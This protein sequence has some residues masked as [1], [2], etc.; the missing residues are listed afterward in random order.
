M[1]FFLQSSSSHIYCGGKNPRER[2][3]SKE[4]GSRDM[5]LVKWLRKNNKKVMAVVVIVI[6]FGFVGGAYIRQLSQRRSELSKTVA[7]FADNKKITNYDRA[8]ARRE[9]ETLRM[10]RTDVLLRNIVA[11]LSRIQDLRAFVL[12]ELLFSERTTSPQSV[13]YI[14]RL[15][16]FSDYGISDEQIDDIYQRSVGSEIYWLLLKKEAELAGIK[17]ANKYAGAQLARAIS[18]F[19]RRLPDFQ[20]LTYERLISATMDRQRIAEKEILATFAKLVAVLEYCVM[21]CA[22]E[23]VTNSQV[24]HDSIYEEETIDVEFVRFDSAVFAKIQNEPNDGKIYEHFQKYKTF[25]AGDVSKENPYGFGYK[26]PDRVQLEYI[27][28]MLDDITRIVAE[29]TDDEVEEYYD[30]H[31]EEFYELVPSDP[32]DPNSDPVRQ[33]KGYTEVASAISE[34]LLQRKVYSK[35]N[36]ILQEA[37]TRTEAGLEGTE[38][39]NLSTEQ[40]REMVGDYNAVAKQLSEEHK[41][42]VYAGQTGLLTA[43]DIQKDGYLGRLYVEGYGHSPPDFI[44]RVGLFRIVFSIDELGTSHLGPFDTARPRM[45]ENIGPLK[46]PLGEVIVLVRVID[47]VKPSVAES[48]NQVYDKS[49][50]KLGQDPNQADEA[51]YSVKEKVVEDLKKLAAMDTAKSKTEEFI[52]QVVMDG[53]DGAISKSNQL[54]GQDDQN[55]IDPNV[56]MLREPTGL[57]RISRQQMHKLE[58]Q[59]EGN[60]LGQLLVNE[61]K[62]QAEF[63]NRLYSLIPEDT[64]S[65]E[66][67]PF[68][69]KFEPHLSYYCL[70]NLSVKRLYQDQYETVKPF[71]IFRKDLA[72]SQYLAVIHFNPGNILDRMNFRLAE[73]LEP[74]DA[75]EPTE[76][77]DTS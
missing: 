43:A 45:H 60:P 17:I 36:M 35:S 15:I 65:L 76:S 34:L 14:K 73:E 54:Y 26:I 64:N 25:F 21:V 30:K 66:T 20:G 49:A 70:K 67:V 18:E 71:H 3:T 6:M 31:R 61:F 19:A 22:S 69:L 7:Y 4:T 56:F 48:L 75:N 40:F 74:V 63:A 8:I 58:M 10:L 52:K 50:L 72:Q 24:M 32:N 33:T 9:L 39:Q 77:E 29:P 23:D 57:R 27:A 55:E 5:N 12:G 16:R 46:D 53:W 41:T 1:V 44:N 37:K 62:T 13:K 68:I 38:S 42:K 28:V 47:A 2:T 59:Y 51:V 11:P